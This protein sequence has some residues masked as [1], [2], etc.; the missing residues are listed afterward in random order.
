MNTLITI[1]ILDHHDSKDKRMETSLIL[2]KGSLDQYSD[3]SIMKFRSSFSNLNGRMQLMVRKFEIDCSSYS[4][5]DALFT[6]VELVFSFNTRN[7]QVTE[8]QYDLITHF[9]KKTQ[10]IDCTIGDT[11]ITC[12]NINNVDSFQNTKLRY[13]VADH[14][15]DETI[16]IR[17]EH[18]IDQC[19]NSVYEL[20]K[21]TL[22]SK[23]INKRTKEYKREG[24][25]LKNIKNMIHSVQKSKRKTSN[26]KC[27]LNMNV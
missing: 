9:L 27:V 10:D 12:D 21:R 26:I 3:N 16:E 25:R 14:S 18:V 1:Q 13:S 20:P 6:N 19:Y 2:H 23:S 4:N 8:Q 17:L 7:I 24:D 5:D 11:Q 22:S 15:E